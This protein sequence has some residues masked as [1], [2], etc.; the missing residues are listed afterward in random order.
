MMDEMPFLN[1][2]WPSMKSLIVY[3]ALVVATAVAK[4]PRECNTVTEYK[5]DGKKTSG[6]KGTI[7]VEYTCKH[8]K[9]KGA[10][11]TVDLDIKK[12]DWDALS[13]ADGNCTGPVTEF[14]WHIHTKWD[15]KASGGSLEHCA[16]A[17]TANHYDP[18]FACGPN[19]DNVKDAKCKELTPVYKCTPENYKADPEACEKGDLSGKLGSLTSKKGKIR[20]TWFDPHYPAL[21]ESTP[22]WN[23]L[24]HAVCGS[25]TPRFVCATATS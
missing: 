21:S 14:K 19:S 3:V 9:Y 5:F 13:K 6:V 7:D 17:K 12:A 15:N 22:E 20:G 23:M 4:S 2:L 16:L 8:S 24:L 25:S 10:R 1:L 11:I 18:T